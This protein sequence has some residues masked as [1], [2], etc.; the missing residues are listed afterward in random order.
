MANVFNKSTFEYKRSVNT[1]DFSPVEWAINPDVDDLILAEVP[2]RYWKWNP[3]TSEVVEMT[4]AEKAQRDQSALVLPRTFVE[5]MEK[6]ISIEESSTKIY[7]YLPE[8]GVA[9][10]EYVK[11]STNSSSLVLT[12]EVDGIDELVLDLSDPEYGAEAPSDWPATVRKAVDNKW[13]VQ[14]PTAFRVTQ[15]I[16]VFLSTTLPG[17]TANLLAGEVA[18]RSGYIE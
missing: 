1:P 7:D 13:L 18:G 5:R 14:P 12:V 15:R 6:G 16:C 11:F 17:T 8:Q 10:V 3:L 9:Y 2:Q 4:E